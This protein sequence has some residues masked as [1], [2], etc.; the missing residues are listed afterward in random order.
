MFR[1]VNDCEKLLGQME[2]S[3]YG[4]S[5][6]LIN[7]RN[8]MVSQGDWID[9]D[10]KKLKEQSKEKLLTVR[11]NKSIVQIRRNL[12]KAASVANLKKD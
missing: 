8:F 6:K 7:Y 2:R 3:I 5:M 11:C 10:M 9:L 12:T 4:K 1:K